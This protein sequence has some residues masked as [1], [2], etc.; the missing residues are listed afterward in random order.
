MSEAMNVYFNL[1]SVFH[2]KSAKTTADNLFS[3]D[4]IKPEGQKQETAAKLDSANIGLVMKDI[5][6]DLFDP[7]SAMSDKEKQDFIDELQRK[8]KAGEELSADEMQ[9][10]RINA[11]MEYAKMAKVQIQREILK[12]Q[13]E[14]CKSKEEAHDMYVQAMS[15]ISEDDPARE[16][17]MAAYNNVYEEFKKS[18]EYDAL[19]KKFL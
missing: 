19:P 14:S 6:D 16:E 11:P 12:R 7:T 2:K 10:L 4:K 3:N 15:R 1:S 17:T 13:L 5:V 9:Y 8:I 18:D